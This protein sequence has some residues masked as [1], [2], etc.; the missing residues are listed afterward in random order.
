MFVLVWVTFKDSCRLRHVE[1]GLPKTHYLKVAGMCSTFY[2]FPDRFT[3]AW[4]H[5]RTQKTGLDRT[6]SCLATIKIA[7]GCAPLPRAGVLSTYNAQR[8]HALFCLGLISLL[9][10]HRWLPT[11]HRSLQFVRMDLKHEAFNDEEKCSNE[12]GTKANPFHVSAPTSIFGSKIHYCIYT[13]CLILGRSR[14]L[15]RLGPSDESVVILYW[16]CDCMFPP[17]ETEFLDFGD[18]SRT[19]TDRIY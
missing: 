5:R 7:I 14:L 4:R 16:R 19:D 3:T 8:L 6:T 15:G 1:R 11:V 10:L 13:W 17:P 9:P 2:P 18:V 12:L